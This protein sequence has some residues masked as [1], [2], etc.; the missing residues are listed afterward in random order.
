MSDLKIISLNA[1]GLNNAVKRKKILL[2]ME[3]D[4]TDVIF[5]QETHLRRQEHEK[6]KER[7][8]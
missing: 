1:D 5:L 6:V 3:R 4:K 2:Q 8:Q 7:I